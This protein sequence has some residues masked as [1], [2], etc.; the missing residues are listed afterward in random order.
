MP[1]DNDLFNSPDAIVVLNDDETYTNMNGC[2]VYLLNDSVDVSDYDISTFAEDIANHPDVQIL[3]VERLVE[4]YLAFEAMNAHA[5]N[6]SVTMP[7]RLDDT[8]DLILDENILDD[9][10]V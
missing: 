10:E 8:I 5:F 7:N 9:G 1:R 6:V 4:F 2:H 3:S